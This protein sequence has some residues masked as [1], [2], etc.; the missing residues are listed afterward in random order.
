MVTDGSYTFFV[1]L[2]DYKQDLRMHKSVF[3]LL[4]DQYSITSVTTH[5]HHVFYIPL[6]LWF[7]WLVRT[8]LAFVY[9]EQL[10]LLQKAFHLAEYGPL[11]ETSSYSSKMDIVE[12]QLWGSPGLF[13]FERG[14]GYSGSGVGWLGYKKLWKLLK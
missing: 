7:L 4:R 1:V 6:E 13:R 3:M 12:E 5:L 10:I 8:L 14:V 2:E 11:P 9:A